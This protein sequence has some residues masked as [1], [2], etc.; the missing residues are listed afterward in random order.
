[1]NPKIKLT[2]IFLLKYDLTL[3]NYYHLQDSGF[4]RGASPTVFVAGQLMSERYGMDM[5]DVMDFMDRFK[6]N[7]WRLLKSKKPWTKRH[8]GGSI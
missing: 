3:S 7:W 1:M 8:R 2:Y 5:V 4:G 6:P